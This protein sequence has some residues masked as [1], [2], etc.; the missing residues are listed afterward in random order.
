MRRLVQVLP[1][2]VAVLLAGC[3]ESIPVEAT[4]ADP[5]EIA[6]APG[7]V[8]ATA[9]TESLRV[10][11]DMLIFIPCAAG[12]AGEDVAF[13]GTLHLLTHVTTNGSSGLFRFHAQPQGVSG[14]G[15]TTGVRYSAT[16]VTQDTQRFS[17]VNGSSSF[18]F[19]NNFRLIGQGV[20]NNL[21]I[22]Q[23]FHVTYNA[24][25]ELTAE[26]DKASF[27]CK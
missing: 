27:E 24:S 18:T 6:V 20:G 17:L 13:E 16:G 8:D 12:G 11:L 21:L 26:V 14:T 22:H 7:G 1:V 3:Q 23:L 15:Q 5:V 25:G 2:L 9:S 4:T 19:V 10:P